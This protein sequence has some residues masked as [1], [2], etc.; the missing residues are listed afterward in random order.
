MFQSF[1]KDAVLEDNN[2]N[3]L[4]SY[5]QSWASSE[6]EASFQIASYFP[7]MKEV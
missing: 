3:R 1:I 6:L 4:V 5:K 2:Y 7:E